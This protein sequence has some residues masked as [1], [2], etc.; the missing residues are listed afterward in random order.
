MFDDPFNLL[1]ISNVRQR[2]RAKNQEVGKLTGLNTA[3]F[4]LLTGNPLPN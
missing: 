4:I 1:Q 2:V 3:I